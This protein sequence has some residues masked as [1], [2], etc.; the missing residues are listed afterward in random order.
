MVEAK[1]IRA[2][3]ALLLLSTSCTGPCFKWQSYKMDAHRTGVKWSNSE[4]VAESMGKVEDGLYTSPNGCQFSDCACYKVAVDM[5]DAQLDMYELKLPIGRSSM[6]FV[7]RTPECELGDLLVDLMMKCTEDAVGEK[8]DVGILNNGGIRADLNAGEILLDDV[9]SMLPFNNRFCYVKIYG[10][11]LVEI[12]KF[13]ARSGPQV[14]GGAR[15]VVEDG[16]LK[17]LSVGGKRVDEQKLYGVATLDFLLDGGDSLYVAK[18]AKKLVITDILPKIALRSM[19]ESLSSEGKS[20]EY[21]TD[22]RYTVLK[23]N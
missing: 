10:R 9:Y 17:E 7:R 20:L 2:C 15:C 23:N 13:I 18:N 5:L 19:I 4:N 3:L 22:G 16:I 6:D 11:D 8:V 1:L 14:I 12:F 21:H